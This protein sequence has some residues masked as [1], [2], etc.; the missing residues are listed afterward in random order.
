MSNMKKDYLLLKV[1]ISCG[2]GTS[3]QVNK[4][5]HCVVL[6]SL[7]QMFLAFLAWF[8]INGARVENI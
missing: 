5:L 3:T 7:I 2:C 6:F 4:L 1:H 8:D